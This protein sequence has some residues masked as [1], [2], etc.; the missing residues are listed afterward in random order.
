MLTLRVII[1]TFEKIAYSL[2]DK[3][4]CACVKCIT[5]AEM[6][7]YGFPKKQTECMMLKNRCEDLVHTQF[8]FFNQLYRDNLINAQNSRVCVRPKPE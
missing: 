3:T 6:D 2:E 7:F 8:S 5:S 4:H 1:Q